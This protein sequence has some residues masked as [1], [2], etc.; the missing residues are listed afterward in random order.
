MVTVLRRIPAD[1]HVP[2]SRSPACQAIEQLIPRG[3]IP[4][5]AQEGHVF[6]GVDRVDEDADA[7]Q[8]RKIAGP[9]LVEPGQD[10]VRL[11][12]EEC[13][14]AVEDGR[15]LAVDLA[16]CAQDAWRDGRLGCGSAVGHDE[17]LAGE[18]ELVD[19]TAGLWRQSKEAEFFRPVWGSH[20][21][22]GPS[23]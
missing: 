21:D 9:D 4:P 11:G 19:A 13:V 20:D 8:L 1:E 7:P 18:E 2:Q 3:T 16:R 17:L 5:D 15:G 14:V 23:E 12:D 10:A 6:G 22:V